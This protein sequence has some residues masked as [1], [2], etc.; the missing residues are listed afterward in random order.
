MY[1]AHEKN[2]IQC[3]FFHGLLILRLQI[4]IE[5]PK[6]AIRYL[7]NEG[8]LLGI[9]LLVGGSM[10]AARRGLLDGEGKPVIMEERALRNMGPLLSGHTDAV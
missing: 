9:Q 3:F 10:E 5:M 4:C 7:T 1:T 8:D 6:F 2:S